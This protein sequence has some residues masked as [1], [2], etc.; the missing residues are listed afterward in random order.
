MKEKDK[1]QCISSTIIYRQQLAAKV[2]HVFYQIIP[3]RF[4]KISK[5]EMQMPCMP[6]YFARLV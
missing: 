2:F 3:N 4:Q 6:M 1:I 5:T